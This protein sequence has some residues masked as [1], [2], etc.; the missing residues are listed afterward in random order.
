MSDMPEHENYV[1]IGGSGFLGSYIVQA[2]VD[3]AEPSVAVYDL[4]LPSVK[5]IIDGPTYYAGDI[6]D[7]NKLTGFLKEV[8]NASEGSFFPFNSM[9][10]SVEVLYHCI[11]YRITST[12]PQ[13]F[14][15]LP[16]Q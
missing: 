8:R 5:D 1:V 10:C 2:L 9:L 15:L 12:R 3:R 4:S 13:G 11:P 14:S 7:E 6:L 16:Y